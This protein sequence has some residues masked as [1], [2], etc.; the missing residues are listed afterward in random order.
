MG[1]GVVLNQGQ[2]PVVFASRTLSAAERNYT[3]ILKTILH[4]EHIFIVS[5]SSGPSR[6]VLRMSFSDESIRNVGE[7]DS[8]KPFSLTSSEHLPQLLLPLERT[9]SDE[10]KVLFF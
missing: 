3:N 4:P 1:I 7:R 5:V 10:G 6:P 2:R 9:F 8:I